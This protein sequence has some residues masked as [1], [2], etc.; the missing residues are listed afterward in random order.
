M[1]FL[2]FQWSQ[3]MLKITSTVKRE[4]SYEFYLLIAMLLQYQLHLCVFT[5]IP[6]CWRGWGYMT[7]IMYLPRHHSRVLRTEI[8]GVSILALS[9]YINLITFWTGF[10]DDRGIQQ[11]Q[12]LNLW[13]DGC[14]SRI[15]W[16]NHTT[17]GFYN[18]KFT[19]VIHNKLDHFLAFFKILFWDKSNF[20]HRDQ[21]SWYK[22]PKSAKLDLIL[23][24]IR[25]ALYLIGLRE[26]Q[27]HWLVILH[28]IAISTSRLKKN[29]FV[30]ITSKI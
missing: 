14:L 30:K 28:N 10:R 29:I 9:A 6:T 5:L 20:D 12:Q 2:Y 24:L 25:L 18:N 16:N 11:Q 17:S 7:W 27:Q 21:L 15:F 19:T 22:R 3:N 8:Q 4:N 1:M 13:R 23:I 26:K